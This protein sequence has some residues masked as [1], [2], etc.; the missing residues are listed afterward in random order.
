MSYGISNDPLVAPGQV[1]VPASHRESS[2]HVVDQKLPVEHVSAHDENTAFEWISDLIRPRETGLVGIEFDGHGIVVIGGR[3]RRSSGL[4][5]DHALITR[6][7]EAPDSTRLAGRLRSF[8]RRHKPEVHL[9]LSTPRAVVRQYMVPAVSQRQREA[10]ALWEGQKLIPFSLKA[11]AALYGLAFAAVGDR[12]W[13]TTLVA[14]PT[15]DVKAILDAVASLDWNLTSVSLIGTQRF[16]DSSTSIAES[17]VAEVSWSDRRGCF[18][19]YHRGQLAFHYDLGPMPKFPASLDGVITGENA[20]RWQRWIDSLGVT[21]SDALDFHLNVNPSIPPTSLKLFGLPMSAATLLTDWNNRF[22]AGV[23]IGDP[24]EELRAGLPDGV[25]QWLTSHPGVIAPVLAA[26]QGNV[27]VDLTPDE[28]RKQK[29]LYK[30]ERIMRSICVLSFAAS[31]AWSGLIWS[32]IAG[33]QLESERSREAL[34]QLQSSP[35]SQKLDQAIAMA[36]GSQLLVSTITGPNLDWMPWFKTVLAVLPQNAHLLHADIEYSADK[37]AVIAHLEGT[38][39]P[40]DVAHTMTYRDW[41]DRMRP[42]CASAPLLANERSV[43][44]NGSEH[45]AFTVEIIAPTALSPI[46]GVTP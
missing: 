15:E 30:R 26:M 27:T 5:L 13:K 34:E 1:V 44:V 11:G 8:V 24:L 36:G 43:D 9:V 10:A 2:A 40:I 35:V 37:N 28:V 14:V 20:P 45:S 29:V 3:K 25:N 4:S 21:V 32:H 17:A 39:S 6:Y 12:G 7:D 19:V 46:A 38:L 42:L 33:H 31:I 23:S 22:P 16:N 41:F 18:A